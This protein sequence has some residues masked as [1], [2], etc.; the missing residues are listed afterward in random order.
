MPPSHSW[1][2]PPIDVPW[3]NNPGDRNTFNDNSGPLPGSGVDNSHLCKIQL[4]TAPRV[5]TIP[6]PLITI[7]DN[8]TG[9]HEIHYGGVDTFPSGGNDNQ[10]TQG[11]TDCFAQ[12]AESS[13]GLAVAKPNNTDGNNQSEVSTRFTP[14]E[15]LL[16]NNGLDNSQALQLPPVPG[17]AMTAEGMLRKRLSVSHR[18]ARCW[19]FLRRRMNFLPSS[20]VR[21]LSREGR[22]G[23]V[24]YIPDI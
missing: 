5:G 9:G 19:G 24:S 3:D 1:K 8:I 6:L 2:A 21:Q 20:K 16:C 14:P 22:S 11:W 15:V 13:T 7:A 17:E 4:L 18:S 12:E 23:I 10:S